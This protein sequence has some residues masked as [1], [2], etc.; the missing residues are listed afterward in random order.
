MKFKYLD[1]DDISDIVVHHSATPSDM[2]IGAAE[3]DLWHRQRGWL[4]IGYHAVV[5]RDGSIEHGRNVNEQG[6]HVRHHNDTSVGICMIGGIDD[7]GN[8]VDNFTEVQYEALNWLLTLMQAAYPRAD[9]VR[10]SDLDS[11]TLCSKVRLD[12]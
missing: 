2:D 6:A 9:I 7:D 3:I 10:H 1:V 4:A 11:S 5:R 12:D 8:P